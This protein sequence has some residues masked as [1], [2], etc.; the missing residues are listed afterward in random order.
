V[1]ARARPTDVPTLAWR[2]VSRR[3]E[4]TR[5]RKVRG[6]ERLTHLHVRSL[7]ERPLP[8]QVDGDYIGEIEEAE[9]GVLAGALRVVS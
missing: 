4:V 5:S 2:A 6:F 1:L 8:L 3:A 7:D 9:L